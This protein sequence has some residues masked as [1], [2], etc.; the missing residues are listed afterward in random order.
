M[1]VGS[2]LIVRRTWRTVIHEMTVET[3]R[4][5]LSRRMEMN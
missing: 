1:R 2:A 4:Q 3:E 5:L